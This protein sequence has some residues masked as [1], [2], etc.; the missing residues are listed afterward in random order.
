MEELDWTRIDNFGCNIA[1]DLASLLGVHLNYSGAKPD[2]NSIVNGFVICNYTGTDPSSTLW[3][4]KHMPSSEWGVVF[5][6][7]NGNNVAQ[8]YICFVTVNFW[9][10]SKYT[11]NWSNWK[12]LSFAE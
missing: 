9:C 3:Q 10:R 11:G 5:S 1:A 8:I 6:Y 7:G 2:L 4:E 12:K